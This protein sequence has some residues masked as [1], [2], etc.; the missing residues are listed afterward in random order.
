VPG[1]IRVQFVDTGEGTYYRNNGFADFEDSC[2]RTNY[3]RIPLG[4]WYHYRSPNLKN[5]T[6]TRTG[7]NN[8][9]VESGTPVQ[10]LKVGVG[11]SGWDFEG[12]FDNVRLILIE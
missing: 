12:Y 9:P 4:E 1:N 7:P 5:V 11:G 6:T 8:T 10:I 3:T 2:G